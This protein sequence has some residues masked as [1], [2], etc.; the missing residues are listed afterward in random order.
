MK[1]LQMADGDIV[2]SNGSFVYIS[3]SET[4][5]QRLENTLRLDKGSWFFNPEIGIP[6]FEIY[7]KKAVSERLIRSHVERILKTDPEVT[8]INRLDISFD[9]KLRK[10]S[11]IFEVE[12]IYGPT[13]GGLL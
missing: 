1:T 6:W 3:D 5:K 10:I 9:R 7:N 8:T 12:T 13:T 11:I 2:F 4:I